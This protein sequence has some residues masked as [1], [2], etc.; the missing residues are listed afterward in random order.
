M[1]WSYRSLPTLYGAITSP[2]LVETSDERLYIIDS[3][4]RM[5]GAGNNEVRSSFLD[6]I[7]GMITWD[8][9][10]NVGARVYSPVQIPGS[11]NAISAARN[12]GGQN[13]VVAINST[14]KLFAWGENNFGQLGDNTT[15][16]KSSPVAIGTSS[17][18]KVTAGGTACMALRA[19]NTLWTWG[20]GDT[21]ELGNNSTLD[22]SSPVQVSGTYTNNFHIGYFGDGPIAQINTTLHTFST[23][24]YQ[25]WYFD[26]SYL[27]AWGDTLYGADSTFVNNDSPFDYARSNPVSIA[28]SLNLKANV[29]KTPIRIAPS[30]SWTLAAAGEDSYYAIDEVNQ[31]YAWGLNNAGQLGFNNTITRSSP[32]ALGASSWSAVAAGQSFVVAI[33]AVGRLFGW[34]RAL[35]NGTAINRSS[36]ILVGGASSFAAV[37]AGSNFAAALDINNRLF[38]WGN[39]NQGQLGDGTTVNKSSPVLISASVS[40]VAAGKEFLAFTKQRLEYNGNEYSEVYYTGKINDPLAE[41]QILNVR[42]SAP[43]VLNQELNSSWDVPIA[44]SNSFSKVAAGREHMLAIDNNNKLFSWGRNSVG[45]LGINSTLSRSS[46]V[47]VDATSSYTIVA[48]GNQFSAIRK[49]SGNVMT[50]GLGDVGNLG[51]SSTIN[52]SSPV[53]V[54]ATLWS[55]IIVSKGLKK[56]VWA[57]VDDKLYFWGDPQGPYN[58]GDTVTTGRSA[59]TY[60]AN[61]TDGF[62]SVFPHS[63]DVFGIYPHKSIIIDSDGIV[64][65]WDTDTDLYPDPTPETFTTGLPNRSSPTQIGTN[66]NWSYVAAGLDTSFAI[67][68]DY[69]LYSWGSNITGQLGDNDTVTRS[70]PVKVGTSSW[71][72][73]AATGN[74][75]FGLTFNNRLYGWGLNANGQVGDNT[76][77]DKSNPTLLSFTSWVNVKADTGSIIASRSDD[78]IYGWGLNAYGQLGVGDTVDRSSPTLIGSSYRDVVR[79]NI[80]TFALKDNTLYQWGR[81]DYDGADHRSSPVSVSSEHVNFAN[82]TA[83]FG[84]GP[85]IGSTNN[86]II[87]TTSANT[88]YYIEIPNSNENTT[89]INLTPILTLNNFFNTSLTKVGNLSYS[90]IGVGRFSTFGIS[91]NTLYAWGRNNYGQL[92]DGTTINRISP[93]IVSNDKNWSIIAGGVDHT[94]AKANDTVYVWGSNESGQLGLNNTTSRSSP[95]VLSTDAGSNTWVNLAAGYNTTAA[96]S[97]TSGNNILYTWGSNIYGQLGQNS[98]TSKSSPVSVSVANVTSVDFGLYHG[99]LVSNQGNNYVYTWGNN[100]FGQLGT[101]STFGRSSPVNIANSVY[102]KVAAGDLQTYF[103][104]GDELLNYPVY[105]YQATGYNQRYNLGNG[106]T[107]FRSSPV[108]IS[109]GINTIA[110]KKDKAVGI[111]NDRVLGWGNSSFSEN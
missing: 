101:N 105:N 103:I 1:A 32:T 14:N 72:A 59:P 98:T 96:I 69:E 15:I 46:P 53:S 108:T 49:A 31:L 36:P 43:V 40:K 37:Y 5:W 99:V 80:Y 54:G 64:K 41:G 29:Q 20:A 109:T 102:A 3:L 50:F 60:L 104:A 30:T 95:T 38:T 16:T 17:W 67:T 91:N 22:R 68:T 12:F 33:D 88:T 83:I 13:Y 61:S 23:W 39:N 28:S 110:A 55:D 77:I 2:T 58:L 52:R 97:N 79:K 71:A 81:L 27:Q 85:A 106:S 44:I 82:L 100:I 66:T 73:I 76:T 26:N 11:W 56:T 47:L 92:G 10:A 7:I 84:P 48:A 63:Y 6:N 24:G 94:I 34:G 51:N 74:T 8:P 35:V 75:T 87:G 93:V 90:S 107:V 111:N 25:P 19:G 65:R 18:L 42:R 21:G 86:Y 45:E 4:K 62:T 70:S 9:A 78:K 89:T 57:E